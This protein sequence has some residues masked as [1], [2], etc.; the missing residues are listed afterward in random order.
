V[1]HRP[2]VLPSQALL[3]ANR[4]EDLAALMA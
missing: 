3:N 1:P 2:V 4:P